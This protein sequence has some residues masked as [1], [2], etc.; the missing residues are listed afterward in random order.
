VNINNH[1]ITNVSNPINNQDASTKYYTDNS[2]NNLTLQNILTNNPNNNNVNINNH[3]ITNV[4][5]PI[6]L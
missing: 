4:L 1:N 6:N 5:D 2:I 3:N